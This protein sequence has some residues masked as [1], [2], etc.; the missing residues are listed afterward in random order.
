MYQDPWG[1]M[2]LRALQS[3][4]KNCQEHH[5][6]CSLQPVPCACRTDAEEGPLHKTAH[7]TGSS[8][9]KASHTVSCVQFSSSV[10][11]DSLRP[12]GL[13]HARLP[14]PSPTPGVYSNSCPLSWRCH[15][16]ISSSV[17]PFSYCLQSFS[18]S[19]S[20]PMSQFFTSGG[21]SIGVSASASVLPMN[22]QD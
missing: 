4:N 6:A 20:F 7:G 3:L 15:P 21:Q 18:A 10:M 9:W 11:S 13:Q 16:T 2:L 8:V 17:T 5:Q 12:H 1:H 19:R 14:C 22:I